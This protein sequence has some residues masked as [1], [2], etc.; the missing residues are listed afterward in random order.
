MKNIFLFFALIS[1]T[2][3]TACNKQDDVVPTN[4]ELTPLT[5]NNQADNLDLNNLI[6]N[7]GKANFVIN[8]EN[9]IVS[10]QDALLITNKSINAVSYEWDFGNG[11]TST[12]AIPDYQYKIHGNYKVKLT[13]TDSFGNK[14]KTSNDIL[15]LCVFGGGQHDQ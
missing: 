11:D 2:I 12:E 6:V 14:H 4:Q 5:T 8:N 9:S 3:F 13:I 15:V 7:S 1:L 10:E